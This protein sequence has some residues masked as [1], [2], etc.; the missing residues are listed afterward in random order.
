MKSDAQQACDF[1]LAKY[2][3]TTQKP[4][5]LHDVRK[6]AAPAPAPVEHAADE[7]QDDG[8]RFK[9]SACESYVKPDPEG[10]GMKCDNCGDWHTLCDECTPNEESYSSDAV[11][12]C[13]ACR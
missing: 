7:E 3:A 8:M 4:D 11:W 2:R 10:N 9:C 12:L 6:A 13:E 5:T 1:F